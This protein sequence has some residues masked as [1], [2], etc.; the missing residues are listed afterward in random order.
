[1]SVRTI[2]ELKADVAIE[3]VLEY[4]GARFQMQSWGE[5]TPVWC[6]YHI[7]E[8]TPAGSMNVLKGVYNCFACGVSG[9]VIDLALQQPDV[10]SIPKAMDW[11]EET[12]CG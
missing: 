9:S 6:P 3:A 1:V 7:N 2:E 8:D 5:N 12:F 10:D 11:L 4:A